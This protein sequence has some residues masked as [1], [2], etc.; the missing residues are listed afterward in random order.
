M[1]KQICLINPWIHDFAAYDFWSKPIGILYLASILR[2]NGYDVNFIDC[3]NPYHPAMKDEFQIKP[4]K[5]R[6]WGNGKYAKEAI[7][8]PERLRN[9]SRRYNRYGIT[10][11]IFTEE[12]M[13]LGK[14]DLVF[15]TSMMTYWYPGVFEAI[16]ITRQT[17]PDSTIVLGGNYATLC[18][19]HA[20]HNSGADIVIA[21]EGEKHI[22][23]LCDLSYFMPDLTHLDSYPY[24][25]FDLLSSIDQVP[26]MTSRG[27]PF[28]C[29][30]CASH[31]LNDGFRVRDPIKVVDEIEFWNRNHG[32]MNF[33][34]Y[35]DAFLVD[36]ANRAIPM[37]KELLRRDLHVSFHCPNGLHLREITGEVSR[38]MLRSGFRTIR[39]GFETS[40]IRRQ[41]ETGGKITNDET[42]AAIKHLKNAGYGSSDIGVYIL[43][44]LPEQSAAEVHESI[45]FIK[46]L[47]ARPVIAE[48]SPIPGTQLWEESIAASPFDIQ[49]DPIFQNNTLIPCR[50]EKLTYEMYRTL[51]DETRRAIHGGKTS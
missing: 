39:F 47:G 7:E 23:E 51:K 28:K 9:F 25:A 43:C 20:R 18:S 21:G 22:H 40:N 35:D 36:S 26:I 48:Y 12:L 29:T 31:L 8:K 38:L 45:A 37:M 6:L 41:M 2:K 1:N 13:K 44:G 4:P 19:E 32:V 5:R 27:C 50:S 24:P 34:I 17:Y 16:D 49:G 33:S 11:R 14:A 15:V 3:L 42:A 30:Y 46:S 10:P